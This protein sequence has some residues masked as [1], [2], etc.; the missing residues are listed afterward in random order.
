M[1]AQEPLIHAPAA[2]GLWRRFIDA[3]A[4][5]QAAW[6]RACTEGGLVGDCS[7]GGYLAPRKPEKVAGRMDYTATCRQCAREV[8]APGGRLGR[9]SRRKG[10]T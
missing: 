1:S 5:N 8:C 6:M 2:A 10:R 9:P 7:C 4:I 3:G